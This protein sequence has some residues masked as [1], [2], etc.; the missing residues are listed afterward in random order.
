MLKYHVQIVG[1]PAFPEYMQHRMDDKKFAEWVKMRGRTIENKDANK[2]DKL[3][4]EFHSHK[5]GKYFIPAEQV[6]CCLINAG[7]Y[8][9]GKVGNATKTMTN[10]VAAMFYVK[11]LNNKDEL[12]LSPQKFII[13][14]RSGVNH[15]IK[16]RVMVVRPK[17]IDWSSEF[18]LSI[19]NDTIT[20]E[21]VKQII[22]YGGSYVGIGS[23]R[24]EHKGPYGRFIIKKFQKMT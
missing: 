23:Y 16:G 22:E 19:D 12:P 4:A 5:N 9:K 8:V 24:P 15:N 7:K 3:L 13:D 11:S 10:V 17:W 18:M 14:K 2:D 21:T 6:R 20:D 1:N